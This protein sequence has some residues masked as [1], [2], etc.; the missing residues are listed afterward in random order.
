M[1]KLGNEEKKIMNG[2]DGEI[3]KKMLEAVILFADFYRAKEFVSIDGPGHMALGFGNNGFEVVSKI[4]DD[5]LE[6]SLTA[7][8]GFTVSSW[9][10]SYL[11]TKNKVF[12]LFYRK[13]TM[14]QKED[15]LEEK[16]SLLG[17]DK[18]NRYLDAMSLAKSDMIKYGDVVCWSD[19]FLST[20]AASALGVRVVYTGPVIDL[21][22]NILGKVPAVELLS[23]EGRKAKVIIKIDADNLP[24]AGLLGVSVAQKSKGKIPYIMGLEKLLK[25]KYDD[26]TLS[27]LKDFS[28]GFSS[29]G[30]CKLFH[31]N[32]ITP[33]ARKLKK[34]LVCENCETITINVQEIEKVKENFDL[35]WKNLDAKPNLC[36]LGEPALSLYQLVYWTN[37][38]GWE[39]K[40]NRRNRLK[41]K[42]MFVVNK[43]VLEQF[44]RLPEYKELKNFGGKIKTFSPFNALLSKKKIKKRII[45]NSNDIRQKTNSKVKFCKDDEI[46]AIITGKKRNKKYDWI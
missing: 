2:V 15:F 19:S 36:V 8:H 30:S 43:D 21:F 5:L 6:N 38:I 45:T 33:E 27:F 20:F 34:Q 39:L 23:K 29:E 40:Q 14:K 3:K 31:I 42:T 7:K 32:A 25:A 16:L 18:K 46:L 17:L 1:I 11:S 35:A 37:E 44:K 26:K 9:L 28:A 4:L 10:Y 12:G 22:C 13:S 41:V 24:D